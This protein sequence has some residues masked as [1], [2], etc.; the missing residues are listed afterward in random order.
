MIKFSLC[1]IYKIIYGYVDLQFAE[2][3]K[4]STN[5]HGTRSNCL[6]LEIECIKNN[7]RKFFFSARVVRFWNSLPREV[8]MS[9]SL[10][11]FKSCLSKSGV[12]LILRE[13]MVQKL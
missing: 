5:A 13:F 10:N 1:F 3:F 7:K 8:V 12:E 11:E 9:K 6:K 2:F 4:F